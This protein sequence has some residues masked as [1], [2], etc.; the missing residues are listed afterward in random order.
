M[1]ESKLNKG[2]PGGYTALDA[3][4]QV[5]LANL[6]SL[7]EVIPFSGNTEIIGGWIYIDARA[8]YRYIIEEVAMISYDTVNITLYTGPTGNNTVGGVTALD[9]NGTY[10][11]LTYTPTN[12]NIVNVGDV[13]G[14]SINSTISNNWI[15]GSIKVRRAQII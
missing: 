4:R 12:N 1:F 9:I 7:I 5:P 15:A 10:P 2:K 6:N 11:P 13:V 14:I 8:W 3:E